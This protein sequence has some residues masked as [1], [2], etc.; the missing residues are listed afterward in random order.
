MEILSYLWTRRTTTLGYIQ[1]TLAVLAAGNYFGPEGAK[2]V[3]LCNA[4]L[5]AWLGHYNNSRA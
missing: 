1:V 3:T 4:L 2:A 5:V